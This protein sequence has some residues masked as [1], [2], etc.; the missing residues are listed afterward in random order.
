MTRVG[1]IARATDTG[2]GTQTLNF[3]RGFKP[4]ST[5]LVCVPNRNWAD[6]L[7]RYGPEVHVTSFVD[8][9]F[10][11]QRILDFLRHVDVVFSVETL[12]S[13]SFA[14]R[15]RKVGIKTIVQ[16]NPEFFRR[17]GTPGAAP[18]PDEWVWPTSWLIDDMPS[19]ILLPVPVTGEAE[20]TA[21]HP[22]DD[23]LTFVHVAGH[24]AAGDRNGTELFCDAIRYLKATCTVR[25]VGQD[26]QLPL[27]PNIPPNV[28]LEIHDIGLPDR[29]DM[30]RGAHVLVSPRRYGGLSLPVQEAME[31]GLAVMMT[32]CDPNWMW[33]TIPIPASVGTAQRTPYGHIR[34]HVCRARDIAH[35]MDRLTM[36]RDT[37]AAAQSQA[38]HWA[39]EN[40]WAKLRHL[41]EGV[42]GK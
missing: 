2:L 6:H 19:Q 26:G 15:C 35:S 11:P 12:Y 13:W 18:P 34:T 38:L 8:D 24:R 25:I 28:T 5:L 16:G 39:G 37:L 33:P 3:Y 30:Y 4:D 17:D 41:Y 21:A 36:G 27:P 1:L 20:V 7:Q 29:W 10:E 32:D 42:L 9:H 40:T 23:H 22:D 14:R 31:S